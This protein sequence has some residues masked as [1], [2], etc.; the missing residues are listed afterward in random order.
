MS[1]PISPLPASFRTRTPSH[2]PKPT[3]QSLI[4][5]TKQT[6]FVSGRC[7][8]SEHLPTVYRVKECNA[9]PPSNSALSTNPPSTPSSST[10]QLRERPDAPSLADLAPI[11]SEKPYASWM[12]KFV[13]VAVLA[14]RGLCGGAP[15]P[16]SRLCRHMHRDCAEIIFRL[17]QAHRSR[18]DLYHQIIIV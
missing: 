12:P 13:L 4:L 7:Q 11:L 18:L 15:P 2:M 6:T 1:R 16:L 8:H 9:T 10:P 5:Q 3:L 17:Q 14:G